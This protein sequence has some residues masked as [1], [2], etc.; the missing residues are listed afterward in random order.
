VIT[1]IVRLL[2]LASLAI[3]LVVLASFAIFAYNQSK[4]ASAHQT[5]EI[6][7]GANAPNTP[8]Q[9]A[10]E[11][12][13]HKTIDEASDDFTSPFAGVISGSSNEWLVRG[14]KLLLALAIYGFG[15]GFLARM[16][17]IRV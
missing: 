10:H 11:S 13:L 16:V 9:P 2:R 5:Q 14:V 3:C 6:V 4:K 17:R 12:S 8:S 1:P 15:C 7:S